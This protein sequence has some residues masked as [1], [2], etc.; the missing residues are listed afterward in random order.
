MIIQRNTI[1]IDENDIPITVS[2]DR[3]SHASAKTNQTQR[4]VT[5]VHPYLD[6]TKEGTPSKAHDD[7]TDKD[8]YV[9]KCIVRHIGEEDALR[10]VVRSY[11][12][13]TKNDTV[14]QLIVY[15]NMLSP[16]IGGEL[17]VII[18]NNTSQYTVQKK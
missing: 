18:E 1:T 5:M 4:V 6:A 7:S 8:E 12:Y 14:H 15:L 3:V 13:G 11:V 10:Y 2:I 16:P 9:I 17:I